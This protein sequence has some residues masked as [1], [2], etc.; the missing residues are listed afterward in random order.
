MARKAQNTGRQEAVEEFERSLS[1]VVASRQLQP[2]L[3]LKPK[4]C[5]AKSNKA[6]TTS[7]VLLVW[8]KASLAYATLLA[9]FFGLASTRKMKSKAYLSPSYIASKNAAWNSRALIS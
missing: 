8:R 6:K 7:R 1:S 4:V 2:P 5:I 3:P 9:K